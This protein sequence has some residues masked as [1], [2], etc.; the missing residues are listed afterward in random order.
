MLRI[1]WEVGATRKVSKDNMPHMIA[2]ERIRI[3]LEYVEGRK[4]KEV[5]HSNVEERRD[6]YHAHQLVCNPIFGTSG[7]TL[8]ILHMLSAQMFFLVFAQALLNKVG[9]NIIQIHNNVMW[10]WQN[11]EEYS[12]HSIW[13]GGIF[14][15]ILPIPQNTVMDINNGMVKERTQI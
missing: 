11:Y 5:L 15:M 9:H 3:Y 4:T 14:P 6:H 1:I 13:M 12:A 7:N 10:D 2:M 8:V